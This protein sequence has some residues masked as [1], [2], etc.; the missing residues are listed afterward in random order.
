[1]ADHAGYET[2]GTKLKGPVN[3]A[4]KRLTCAGFGKQEKAILDNISGYADSGSMVL[5]QAPPGAG[6][7]TMLNCL[8]GV[9]QLYKTVNGEVLYNGDNIWE[10]E[11]GRLYAHAISRVRQEDE[12]YAQLT[13]R[14][15]LS[16][17]ASC[18][19]P[20]FVP[21]S[22]IIQQH[23]VET[24]ASFLG[25]AHTMDTKVGNESLRGVS[26]GE[27][28]RVTIAEIICG[29]PSSFLFLDNISKGL[30]AAT[31]LDICKG[32]HRFAKVTDSVVFCSLQQIGNE[33][34]ELF[35]QV[36][37]LRIIYLQK[38]LVE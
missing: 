32:I 36:R 33:A 20:D 38:I 3:N 12:H 26:G 27:K 17:A 6:T 37:R 1:M 19:F 22:R 35:D 16:F 18:G 14:E 5:I 11:T 15:T 2:V 23:R 21:F 29:S 24:V 25:I 13:V 10:R 8:S 9:T 34:F 28:K 31:T 4:I 7:T 30:D